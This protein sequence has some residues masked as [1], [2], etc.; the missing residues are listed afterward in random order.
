MRTSIAGMAVQV[1]ILFLSIIILPIYFMS[2]MQ[3]Y[4]DL[5]KCQVAARN[6]VDYVIDNRQVSESALAELNISLAAV[7][8]PVSS[9]VKRETRVID[10]AEAAG[11]TSIKWVYTEWDENT[12]WYQGDLVTV[13]IEQESINMLQQIAAVFLGANYSNMNIRLVGMVR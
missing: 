5:N 13:E 1:F 7:S 9:T 11:E 8:T 2:I 6:F 12:V 4:K 3:Y 10:P